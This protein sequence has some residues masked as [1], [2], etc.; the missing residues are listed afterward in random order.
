VNVY[1]INIE[2]VNSPSVHACVTLALVKRIGGAPIRSLREHLQMT[3]STMPPVAR[4]R[5]LSRRAG[6]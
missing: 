6:A 3:V 2:P 1:N 4:R 5:L